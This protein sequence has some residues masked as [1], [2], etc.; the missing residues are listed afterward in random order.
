MVL[1][2]M[3]KV[4]VV[5]PKKDLYAVVDTLFRLGTLHLEDASSNIP[6]GGTILRRMEMEK[7]AELSSL[8]GRI[9]GTLLALPKKEVD[10]KI[11]QEYLQQFQQD[12]QQELMVRA[13]HVLE[14]LEPI[15]KDLATAKGEQE[16]TLSNLARYEK[17]IDRIKPLE[18]QL[19][20]LEGFEITIILVAREFSD[21][22]ELIRNTLFDLTH[23]QFELISA[24]VDEKTI[25][26]VVV[27]NRRYSESVHSFLFSQNVNEIRLPP[28]YMGKPFHEILNLIK[29][30]KEE[31]EEKIQ[32][33]NK[34]LEEVSDKNFEELTALQ[35]VLQDRTEE[36]SVYNKFAQTDYTF[37]ISGWVPKKFIHATR[38]ALLESFGT[39]VIFSE[40]AVRPEEMEEAPTFYDNPRIVKPFEYILQL[41]SPPRSQEIDPSPLITIFFPIFFGLMVGD[42]A[43]G[44]IILAFALIM[45]TRFP[46]DFWAQHLMNILV[47]SS[48]P[49]IFFGFIFGEFFGN[50]GE[51]LGWFHPIEFLGIT[52]NRVEAVV[53]LLILAIAIG[54]FHVFLGLSLG[55]VNSVA[56]LR[57]GVH[58]RE[59]RKHIAERGGMIIMIT[60]L[61]LVLGAAGTVA[62][63]ILLEP[64]IGMM[65]LALPLLIYG[66]GFFGVFEII[67][68]VGNILSYARIM[69]I[70]M[71][72]VILALVANQLGGMMD[73]A[74]LGFFIAALLHILNLVLAVF[75]PFLHSLRL[76]LVEFHS[77]FYEGGGRLYKPFRKEETK[78]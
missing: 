51:Q 59:C 10:S 29:K 7:A 23:N 56:R 74:L 64:G 44:L 71:A 26:T 38:K 49:A 45:K 75:S 36:L 53:P 11:V 33:I 31:A 54:V 34:E 72:S 42:I 77:K 6:T 1:Q 20:I 70:G 78:T 60:G 62:P 63:R 3:V 76:H 25:A 65:L 28:E 4:Q 57:C 58:V 19:P 47:I 27:F 2:K 67:S 73:V 17:I 32:S 35:Q 14:E 16:F 39:R 48:I 8:L 41:I 21:V 52:W 69:A 68:T 24:D 43:Y 12:S 18:T 13:A 5:G 55:I 66:R 37:I 40:I 9:G 61:L 30:R 15:T 50:L 46:K 22:L